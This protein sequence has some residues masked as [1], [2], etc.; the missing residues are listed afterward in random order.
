MENKLLELFKLADI[1]NDKQDKV[2]ACINYA[3]NDSKKLEISIRSKKD[4]SYIKR[5]EI[6]LR[7]NPLLEWDS[8]IELFKNFVAGGVGNE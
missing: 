7:N 2:Y 8:I 5:C 6:E 1:L 4:F 3:A